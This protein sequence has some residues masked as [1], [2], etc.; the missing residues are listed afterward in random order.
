[1]PGFDASKKWV[2]LAPLQL[3][4]AVRAAKELSRCISLLAE[5][6]TEQQS[7]S[8]QNPD[9]PVSA[10][11]GI[12]DASG[13]APPPHTPII[14]LNSESPGVSKRGF[15]WRVGP[16][17]IEIYGESEGGLCKGIYDFL[18]ALGLSWPKPG[19]SDSDEILP[20]P[21]NHKIYELKTQGNYAPS[22]QKTDDPESLSWKRLLIPD[23][24]EFAGTPKKREALLLWAERNGFD[25]AIF[26]F[27]SIK[28]AAEELRPYALV[29]EAGGWTMSLLVPRRLFVFHR[30]LFRMEGG[31]RK[32]Q[33]HFCPT[34]PETI[35]VI[36]AEARKLFIAA[37]ASQ[38][39]GI[40]TF[41]LWPDLGEEKTWCSCPSC[42]AFS[43]TEQNRIAVNAASDALAE[44][45]SEVTAEAAPG[46]ENSD[47]DK[48]YIS[49]YENSDEEADIV[50]RPNVFK[51]DLQKIE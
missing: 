40:R 20:V 22:R 3:P 13:A 29:P 33:V 28:G 34:H 19:T 16:E 8:R 32:K 21:A 36:R 35:A 26:P 5:G 25:A 41:H 6:S 4:A 12:V 31:K 2:I 7:Q 51:I 17:R 24:G 48:C 1:M 45:I 18:A 15:S 50:L 42:R 11:P 27:R 9:P 10:R 30:E 46:L 39:S 38:T 47:T 37:G 49:I 14:L 44:V 23:K 43:L